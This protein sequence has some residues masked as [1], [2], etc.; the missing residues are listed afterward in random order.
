MCA[1]VGKRSELSRKSLEWTGDS[2]ECKWWR[3]HLERLPL[4][5]IG[6]EEL[7]KNIVVQGSKGWK[8]PW[9]NRVHR[10]KEQQKERKKNTGNVA[11]INLELSYK[12]TSLEL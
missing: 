7:V 8:K 6:R 2:Y 3:T 10:K 4:F 1:S 5:L 9:K 12:K 11:S